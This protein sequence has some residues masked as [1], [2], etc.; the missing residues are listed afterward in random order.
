[1][2]TENIFGTNGSAPLLNLFPNSPNQSGNV[3][4]PF[5]NDSIGTSGGSAVQSSFLFFTPLLAPPQNTLDKDITLNRY[6]G[7]MSKT[8]L[9]LQ[10]SLNTYDNGVRQTNLNMLADQGSWAITAAAK[11]AQFFSLFSQQTST[12]Q[13][14]LSEAINFNQTIVAPYNNSLTSPNSFANNMNQTQQQFAAGSIT[15]A[16][17]NAAVDAYNSAVTAVNAQLQSSYDTYFAG[18]TAYNLQV[19]ANNAQITQI[20][21]LRQQFNIKPDLPL[22][23]YAPVLSSVTLLPENL[24]H[25]PPVNTLPTVPASLPTAQPASEQTAISTAI[26]VNTPPPLSPAEKALL[27]SIQLSLDNINN[28]PLD[29]YNKALADTNPAVTAMKQAISDFALGL[30]NQATYDTAKNNYLTYANSVNPNLNTKFDDYITAINAY[31]SSLTNINAQIDTFNL[32]RPE[33]SKIPRQLPLPVPT[34]DGKLPTSIPSGPSPP[35]ADP[36]ATFTTIILPSVP[37]G[38]A[39]PTRLN[40]FMAAYY[41]AFFDASLEDK[42]LYDKI[43]DNIIKESNVKLELLPGLATLAP[44]D[45]TNNEANVSVTEKGSAPGISGV[46]LTVLIG[47]IDNSALSAIITNQLLIATGNLLDGKQLPPG[48][49]DKLLAFALSAL[50]E[51]FLLAAQKAGGLLSAYPSALT[52][53][54]DAIAAAL[55]AALA[56]QINGLINSG[57]IKNAVAA[58]LSTSGL[59]PAEIAA[60]Q[61][62]LTASVT[63]GLLQFTVSQV[64][65]LL[66]LPGLLPQI[67]SNLP[68]ASADFQKQIIAA[69]DSKVNQVL[70]NQA[71][72]DT[73]KS[74]LNAS[75]N[76]SNDLQSSLNRAQ[77]NR[78]V[79]NALNDRDAINSANDLH[80][81]L[82]SSLN[83]ENFDLPTANELANKAAAFVES[84]QSLTNLDDKIATNQ[85]IASSIRASQDI[86]DAVSRAENNNFETNRQLRGA[87]VNELQNQGKDLNTAYTL[88]NEV[89]RSQ[90]NQSEENRSVQNNA[91]FSAAV[92]SQILVQTNL[93]EEIN[94]SSI[95]QT[96]LNQKALNQANANQAALNQSSNAGNAGTASNQAAPTESNLVNTLAFNQQEQLR[97]EIQ[98]TF[99]RA[100]RSVTVQNPDTILGYN[101]KLVAE[102]TS[103][104]VNSIVANQY[105]NEVAAINGHELLRNALIS[106]LYNRNALRNDLVGN[107]LDRNGIRQELINAALEKLQAV[108]NATLVNQLATQLGSLVVGPAVV[109]TADNKSDII[110]NTNSLLD[111]LDSAHVKSQVVYNE[112]NRD[113]QIENYRLFIN[114]DPANKVAVSLAEFGE[115]MRT[116]ANYYIYSAETGI[117]YSKHPNSKGYIDIII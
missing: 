71:S 20:N 54:S 106:D 81:A 40:S 91:A 12:F 5:A 56:A 37:T 88:A 87:I 43:L 89:L 69:T 39:T 61:D 103:N 108:P 109:A 4:T 101:A 38:S 67:L 46:G 31:N 26:I 107:L 50:Q 45:S 75:I 98:D 70:S 48:L 77:I 2:S 47:G 6:Y 110:Q 23:D 90:L 41:A 117:T 57:A 115:R 102:L 92:N 9:E 49:S 22:Q 68:S 99:L 55:S 13:N 16:Q 86:K 66:N 44:N 105:A 3:N 32:S 84:E 60:V 52:L 24:P 21:L 83:R 112:R 10:D 17:Y 80:D 73:L 29:A 27:D 76:A 100:I 78:A 11:R 97:K 111:L 18:V 113:Q 30:I 79:N 62:T 65:S 7:I 82:V 1:M 104:G 63:L 42:K 93:S 19:D 8:K 64:A 35:A 53:G 59:S 94:Q 15:S 34:G 28:G 51:N 72:V 74:I 116:T 96:A 58:F 114:Q 14:E 36:F 85:A 33:G 95:N 25:N